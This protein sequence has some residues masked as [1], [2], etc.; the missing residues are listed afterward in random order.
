LCVHANFNESVLF[1]TCDEWSYGGWQA[2]F[3]PYWPG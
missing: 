1:L 3:F 2:S